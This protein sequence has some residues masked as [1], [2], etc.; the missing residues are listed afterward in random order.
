MHLLRVIELLQFISSIFLIHLFLKSK[1]PNNDVPFLGLVG[2]G[3]LSELLMTI[4]PTWVFL[5]VLYLCATLYLVTK[6]WKKQKVV[7]REL[8]QYNRNKDTGKTTFSYTV[9]AWIVAFSVAAMLFG[10]LYFLNPANGHPEQVTKTS[11]LM[12]QIMLGVDNSSHVGWTNEINRSGRTIYFSSDGKDNNRY[13]VGYP[14][15]P[16]VITSHVQSAIQ[17]ADALTGSRIERSSEVLIAYIFSF[18]LL[19]G[20]TIALGCCIVMKLLDQMQVAGLGMA[21]LVACGSSALILRYV[22]VSIIDHGFF[23]QPAGIFGLFLIVLIEIGLLREN[24]KAHIYLRTAMRLFGVVVVGHT[25]WILLPIAFVLFG[26]F[27]LRDIHRTF[28]VEKTYKKKQFIYLCIITVLGILVSI[29]PVFAE[30]YRKTDLEKA[31]IS[32]GGVVP[33]SVRNV[34]LWCVFFTVIGALFVTFKLKT[35]FTQPALDVILFIA[36]SG[37]FLAVFIFYQ[38]KVG[39]KIDYY[40]YKLARTVYMIPILGVVL[41]ACLAIGFIFSHSKSMKILPSRLIQSA[42]IIL[43]IIPMSFANMKFLQERA[44]SFNYAPNLQQTIDLKRAVDEANRRGETLIVV[45]DCTPQLVY[46]YQIN[47]SALQPF[48]TKEIIE[49]E[50]ALLLKPDRE[51]QRKK[52]FKQLGPKIY[53]FDITPLVDENAPSD[54]IPSQYEGARTQIDSTQDYEEQLSCS[55]DVLNLYPEK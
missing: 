29:L 4:S 10:G 14:Q 41:L 45:G 19:M 44:V 6:L 31:I 54:R 7:W 26:I 2:A 34:I 43:F 9:Y 12:Q 42:T 55:Q 3:A 24:E 38:V 11:I 21:V 8:Y 35:R 51:N 18:Y 25:W 49:Y 22:A 46:R 48:Y 36:T 32:G 20:M 52:I 33:I 53:Y 37:L 28:R 1:F 50:L 40:G 23:S 27:T 17:T 30:F 39:G 13:A 16:H 47:A 5:W 15:L